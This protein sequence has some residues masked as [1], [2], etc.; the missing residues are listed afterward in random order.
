MVAAVD[1]AEGFAVSKSGRALAFACSFTACLFAAGIL[2]ITVFGRPAAPGISL[3]L[4]ENVGAHGP[5]AAHAANPAAAPANESIAAPAAITQPVYAGKA[6]LAD[7]ALIENTASGPLPRIADDG[8]KPMQ[9]YAAPAA[10]NA[11]FKI[12]I[13]V[14]GL[15]V[16]A[17]ATKAAL[18]NLPAGVTLGFAPYAGDVGEWVSQARGR[19]HEVLLQV[20]MEP[21]DFPDSDPGPHTLRAGQDEAANLQRLSWA[22]SRFTGYAG[23]TNLLGQRFLSDSS[24][25]SPA[26]TYLNRR[27]LYFFDNGAATQSVAPNV[28]AQVGLPAVQS[29]ATIDG[30]QTALEIDSRLSELE[31]QARAN[32]SAVG[33]AFLYP[34]S[35]AR[36]ASWAKGL[37]ARGFVLVPVSAI[38]PAQKQ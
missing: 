10:M 30:I 13:V 12:A 2:A 35:I 36:I 9:A 8:R 14:S 18:D 37:Q 16:S 24:A 15:G 11:K 25:L 22:L 6:L 21:F 1:S 31:A 4:A 28:A 33:S 38:V 17:S 5:A 7:P 26:L 23:V 27:G 19:G 3:E 29:N 20:P 34:V 32:G